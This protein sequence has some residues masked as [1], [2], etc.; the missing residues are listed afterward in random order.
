MF[1]AARKHFGVKGCWT[2]E[3]R[4]VIALPDK[5]RTRVEQMSDLLPLLDKYPACVVPKSNTGPA[6][7]P[8][9]T[10]ASA[11]SPSTSKPT[12]TT[13][14]TATKRATAGK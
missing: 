1:V 10:V 6:V 4:I 7:E 13:R 8:G 3:G 12:I 9:D 11:A 2:M 14:S 5:S